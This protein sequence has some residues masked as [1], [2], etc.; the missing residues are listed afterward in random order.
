LQ[1]NTLPWGYLA[2]DPVA[3]DK[4]IPTAQYSRPF[5]NWGNVNV[6]GNYGHL[7]HHSGTAKVEKRYS[8]GV[9]FLAFYTFG[10]TIDA[11]VSN[12]YLSR[13]LNKGRADWDQTHRFSG[14]MTYEIPVGKGRKFMNRGGWLN[15]LIGGFDFVWAYSIYSGEPLGI[16]ISGQGTQ[17]YPSW[18]PGTGD[19]VLLQRPSLRDGWQ[20]IGNDRWNQANQNSLIACGTATKLGND[21]MTY[22]G[23]YERGNAGRNVWNRQRV[24]AANMSASKEIPIKERARVQFRFDFQNPFK[25]YNWTAPNTN[26]DINNPQFFGKMPA[27]EAR[28][29]HYGGQPLMNLTLAVKW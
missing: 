2:D 6:A 14:S 20:D 23:S 27:D 24:I 9:N 19:V 4:W 7:S 18:M 1:T 29:A 22:S 10:K 5:P 12:M 15:T 25:W 8:R 3:R 16:D 17:T 21:C 28:G 11:N 13:E 26:L